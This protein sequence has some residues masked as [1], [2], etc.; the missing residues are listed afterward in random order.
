MHRKRMGGRMLAAGLLAAGALGGSVASADAST[1]I[2]GS[3]DVT[4]TAPGWDFGGKSFDDTLPGGGQPTNAGSVKWLLVDGIPAP[5]LT[6]TL[7]ATNAKNTCAYMQILYLNSSSNVIHTTNGGEVCVTKDK[8]KQFKVD[9]GSYSNIF[10][11]KVTINLIQTTGLGSS[12][13]GT[14]PTSALGPYTDDVLIKEQGWDFGGVGFADGKPTT[15]GTG[16]W[17]YN[18]GP[19]FHLNGV[20]HANKVGGDCARMQLEYLDVLGNVV[21]EE[22][23]GTVC[24]PD[25]G[26]KGWTV[27]FGG[28]VTSTSIVAVNVNLQTLNALGNYQTA[29]FQKVSFSN[30]YLVAIPA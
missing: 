9:F 27:D 29:G 22:H 12:V 15:S 23:G 8:H 5:R 2:A 24:A 28:A 30:L 11:A 14:S 10:T 7:H 4:I 25:N 1:R 26:H 3:E 19:R 6:G 21:Q 18:L 13:L 17:T 16:T 20:L